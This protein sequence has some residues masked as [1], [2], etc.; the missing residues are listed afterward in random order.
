MVLCS[1]TQLQVIGAVHIIMLVMY[2]NLTISG[3]TEMSLNAAIVQFDFVV[4]VVQGLGLHVLLTKGQF[5]LFRLPSFIL[6]DY[7]LDSSSDPAHKMS[8]S[9]IFPFFGIFCWNAHF[10][11]SFIHL[12]LGGPG[13]EIAYACSINPAL[14]G[15]F[16][17]N[18]I[19][20]GREGKN[21]LVI[22]HFI[23][24]V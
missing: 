3:K 23:S 18:I 20:Y 11:L 1:H 19:F 12:R 8:N 22:A 6:L 24:L 5:I 21:L 17:D 4:S 14:I 9:S 13:E 15:L 7:L 2:E 10:T 16:E